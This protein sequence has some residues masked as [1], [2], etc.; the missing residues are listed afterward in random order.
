MSIYVNRITKV[1]QRLPPLLSSSSPSLNLNCLNF[2]PNNVYLGVT[3]PNGGLLNIPL[4]QVT[5]YYLH[6]DEG[7]I[8]ENIWQG[9]K[10][11]EFVAQQTE[12]KA[13]KVI[14]HYPTETHVVNGKVLPAYWEWRRK[15]YNNKYAVRYPNGYYGRH[16]CLG[17]I[18]N[19]NGKWELLPYIAARKKIYCKVYAELVQRTEAFTMLKSLYNQGVN[20]QICEMDVRPS[21]ITKDVLRT[22]LYNQTDPFGHGYV[23]AACLLDA[24]DLFDE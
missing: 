5:P 4:Y 16:K 3:P 24:T 13:D 20:L 22:E 21:P 17:A 8:F 12:I 7:H 9:S 15:L 18:W 23:L 1:G 10:L 11:Y 2:F 19:D 6:N 14:W